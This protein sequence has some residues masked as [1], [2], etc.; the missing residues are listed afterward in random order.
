MVFPL[1]AA[2]KAAGTI[3][4]VLSKSAQ[5]SAQ[6]RAAEANLLMQQGNL[7]QQGYATQQAAQTNAGQLDLSRKG[8]TEQARGGRAKQAMI[9]DILSRMQDVQINVPGIQTAQ[10]SGGLRPSALGAGGR[11][12]AM[13]MMKQAMAAQ[14]A[15][16]TFSGGQV[17]Q[18]P[19]AP[20]MP[21]AGR[22]EKIAGI[23]GT[24][25]NL[26]GAAGLMQKKA[27]PIPPPYNP[28]AT[29]AWGD[30]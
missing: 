14:T 2:L 5:G 9:G 18:A 3:G 17:L 30:Q 29:G 24:V 20:T 4:G 13:E 12:A 26:A 21:K 8:F 23:L 16:D 19:K 1:M 10:I 15:G 25:G 22:W 6:G 27:A 28:A 11:Q 7:A